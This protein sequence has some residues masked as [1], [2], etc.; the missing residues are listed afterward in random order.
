MNASNSLTGL[1]TF[2]FVVVVLYILA[3]LAIVYRASRHQQNTDDFFLGSRRMP[4]MA[5]GLSI[6]ATLLSSLTYLSLTGEVV[7][8]GIA[9][10]M[11]QLAIIPAASPLNDVIAKAPGWHEAAVVELFDTAAALWVTDK[12]WSSA[13]V[14]P[15]PKYPL[16]LI[17]S[18]ETAHATSCAGLALPSPAA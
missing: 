6:M 8:S 16:S 13:G 2:D 12:W 9:A 18:S 15:V 17:T 5:V 3:T 1:E 4:W 14:G 10:F 11:T 7:K